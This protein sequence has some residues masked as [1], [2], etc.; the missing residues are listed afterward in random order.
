MQPFKL[1]VN[2]SE[3]VSPRRFRGDVQNIFARFS[4]FLGDHAAGFESS[5]HV[6]ISN[7]NNRA[8]ACKGLRTA[9]SNAATSAGDKCYF[10]V[11]LAH[12]S[13]ASSSADKALAHCR[14]I[15]T[16]FPAL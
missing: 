15:S 13:L 14:A 3:C 2:S 16:R 11:E 9:S 4:A 8:F 5:R 6:Y 10:A 7:G 12:I 1:A